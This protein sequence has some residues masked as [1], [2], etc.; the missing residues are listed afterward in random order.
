MIG[1][2]FTT[3]DTEST[4]NAEDPD[5]LMPSELRQPLMV[6][7]GTRANPKCQFKLAS[8]S[9]TSQNCLAIL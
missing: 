5:L 3:E 6:F 8:L 9:E 1:S 2:G 7:A 4:E